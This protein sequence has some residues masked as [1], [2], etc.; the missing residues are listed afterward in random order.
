MART[1][2]DHFAERLVRNPDPVIASGVA[3][4]ESDGAGISDRIL[5]YLWVQ[6]HADMRHS[7]GEPLE[8]Y[9]KRASHI[10]DHRGLR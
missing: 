8:A 6:E 1:D 2:E 9:P 7:G 10:S 4:T 5:E 3:E